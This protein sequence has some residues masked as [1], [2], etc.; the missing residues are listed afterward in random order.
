MFI[1]NT[2]MTEDPKKPSRKSKSKRSQSKEDEQ[3]ISPEAEEFINNLIKSA[4]TRFK[5][6]I[7][8][9]ISEFDGD[10]MALQSQVNEY[11]DDFVIFG[12]TP[13]KRRVLIRYCPTPQGYDSIKQLSREFIGKILM[14]GDIPE[15]F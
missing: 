7:D 3:Y 11:L 4:T 14:D 12:Y 9:R 2:Y 13:D 1:I 15:Y 10:V 6:H 8:D 5:E